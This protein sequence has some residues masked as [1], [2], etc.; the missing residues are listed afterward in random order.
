MTE[1]SVWI[2]FAKQV[3]ALAVLAVLVVYFLN[4]L[5]KISD[6]HKEDIKRL[7]QAHAERMARIMGDY[8]TVADRNSSMY[9]KV[10][11]KLGSL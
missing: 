6:A 1:S 10:L 3:P 11:E 9:E 7:E 8:R 2:E 5:G 4:F